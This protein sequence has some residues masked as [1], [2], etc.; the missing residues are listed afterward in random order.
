MSFEA[1]AGR[2]LVT[3]EAGEVRLD[4]DLALFHVTDIVPS[5]TVV[6]P[7]AQANSV[8]QLNTYTTE[9]G[10]CD[11]A[12]THVIG[13]VFMGGS[14]SWGLAFNRWTTYMGGDLVWAMTAP[15]TTANTAGDIRAFINMMT[16]YRFYASGGKVFMERRVR[17]PRVTGS[18]QA[19][20]LAHTITCKLKAGLWT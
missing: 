16:I 11:P 13:A 4:T 10:S 1:L 19:G 14:G 17:L 5:V 3:N 20:I 6:I 18:V 8:P 15:G 7:A 9:L 2:I 12:A